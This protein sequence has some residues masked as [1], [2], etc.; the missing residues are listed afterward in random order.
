M[1]D[2]LIDVFRIDSAA[3]VQKNAMLL[4]VEWNIIA[5]GIRLAVGRVFVNKPFNNFTF[6]NSLLN[7]FRYILNFYLGV[8]NVS[9][10]YQRPLCAE[11]LAAAL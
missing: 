7:Y 9:D 2:I 8:E 1:A 6:Y 11:T 4:L 10:A 5:F 3:V